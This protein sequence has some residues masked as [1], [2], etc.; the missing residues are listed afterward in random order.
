M[1]S[2]L[3]GG[4]IMSAATVAML[5]AVNF[6]DKTIKNVGKESLREDERN[7]LI[8]AGF[9]LSEIDVINQEIERLNFEM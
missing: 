6:T 4:V 1:I 7:I 9:N 3:M 5:I 2:A 8:N